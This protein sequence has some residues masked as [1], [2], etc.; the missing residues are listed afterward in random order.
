MKRSLPGILY[1]ALILLMTSCGKSTCLNP[2][3]QLRFT[4]FD[5]SELSRVLVEQYTSNGTFATLINVSV[6]D[7][8][9]TTA[10]QSNDTTY[11]PRIDSSGTPIAP[12]YDYV[13]A[14][15][16][17]THSFFADSV[18]TITK[19]S[20]KDVKRKAPASGGCTNDLSYHLDTVAHEAVGGT[21]SQENLL[22]V[23]IV[24]NK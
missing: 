21:Y 11:L 14:I 10:Q 8:G 1:F 24:I 13:I 6:Y 19:I 23:N 7:T 17:V 5:S 3:M 16:G 2:G 22:P 4:G 9:Y 18:F 12:G 20:Y 15:P